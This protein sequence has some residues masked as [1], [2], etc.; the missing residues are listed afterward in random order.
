MVRTKARS[1]KYMPVP[2]TALTHSFISEIQG[3]VHNPRDAPHLRYDSNVKNQWYEKV[4][5]LEL[6]E[7][8]L[9]RFNIRFEMNLG[10]ANKYEADVPKCNCQ[11]EC[12]VEQSPFPFMNFN[13]VPWWVPLK[14]SPSATVFCKEFRILELPRTNAGDTGKLVTEFSDILVYKTKFL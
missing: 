10:S 11:I 4:R 1:K 9:T 12:P 2:S 3:H 7:E 14:N 8:Y 6:H 5:C 13:P